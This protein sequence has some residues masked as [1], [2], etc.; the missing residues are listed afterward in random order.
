M[1]YSPRF[2]LE[3]KYVIPHEIRVVTI[4]VVKNC[5][6][7]GIFKGREVPNDSSHDENVDEID[8][9]TAIGEILQPF[10]RP[11]AHSVWLHKLHHHLPPSHT[12][13]HAEDA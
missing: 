6:M 12:H 1:K 7:G 9:E 8:A 11:H 2:V 3:T 4:N 5:I 13:H 10:L